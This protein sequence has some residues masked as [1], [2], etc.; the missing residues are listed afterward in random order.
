MDLSIP[1]R[2]AWPALLV[3]IAVL[4]ALT[5]DAELFAGITYTGGT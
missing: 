2:V 5:M 3:V 1:P 4:V